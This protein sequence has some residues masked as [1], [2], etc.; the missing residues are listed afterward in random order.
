M[1]LTGTLEIDL[2]VADSQ[3]TQALIAADDFLQ[4]IDFPEGVTAEEAHSRVV[5]RPSVTG[6][7]SAQ[8]AASKSQSGTVFLAITACAIVLGL[9]ISVIGCLKRT[10]TPTCTCASTPT[11]KDLEFGDPKAWRWPSTVRKSPK[12]KL[13]E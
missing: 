8:S 6:H 5:G 13:A 10:R 11:E 2:E 4:T 1:L 3:E 7:E 9:L 12:W